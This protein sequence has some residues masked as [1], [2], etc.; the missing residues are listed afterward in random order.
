MNFSDAYEALEVFSSQQNNFLAAVNALKPITKYCWSILDI[1]QNYLP[2]FAY[3]MDLP[4]DYPP[5]LSCF[6]TES[7]NTLKRSFFGSS[8]SRDI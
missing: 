4:E 7:G 1:A 2:I 3:Q 8:V 6:R 5:I